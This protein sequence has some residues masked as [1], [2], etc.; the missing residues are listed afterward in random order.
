MKHDPQISSA[1]VQVGYPVLHENEGSV[2]E[3]SFSILLVMLMGTILTFILLGVVVGLVMRCS[4]APSYHHHNQPS[5]S[6][7][8]FNNLQVDI[9]GDIH[10]ILRFSNGLS[11]LV[12]QIRTLSSE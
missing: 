11:L 9:I 5:I 7:H 4:S 6:D 10:L 1:N 3:E 8:G 12:N 2:A